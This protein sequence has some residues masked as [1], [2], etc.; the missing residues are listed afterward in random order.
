M[1]TPDKAMREAFEKEYSSV[2]LEYDEGLQGYKRGDIQYEYQLYRDGWKAALSTVNPGLIAAMEGLK[3][4][5]EQGMDA[6]MEA[7]NA[8][9]NDCIALARTHGVEP[10]S[11]ENILHETMKKFRFVIAGEEPV[12]LSAKGR[13]L[14]KAVLDSIGVPYAE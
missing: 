3:Y 1:T 12:F 6:E 5:H 8:A 10:V 9:I 14:I 2:E 7:S 13:D 4:T 11:L